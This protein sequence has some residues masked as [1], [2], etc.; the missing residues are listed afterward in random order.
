MTGEHSWF[1]RGLSKIVFLSAIHHQYPSEI[2]QKMNNMLPTYLE[3][4]T[5]VTGSAVSEL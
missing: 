4:N 5:L 3:M 2:T 1:S